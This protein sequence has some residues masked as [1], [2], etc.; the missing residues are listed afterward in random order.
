MNRLSK[1]LVLA[2]GVAALALATVGAAAAQQGGRWVRERIYERRDEA[3]ARMYA[4]EINRG[5]RFGLRNAQVVS[6][7]APDRWAVDAERYYAAE[8]RPVAPPRTLT[9]HQTAP[10]PN[11]RGIVRHTVAGLTPG[12]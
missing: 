9:G 1:A 12:A 8:P 3:T 5:D 7:G 2:C 6:D 4:A 11:A 10:Q